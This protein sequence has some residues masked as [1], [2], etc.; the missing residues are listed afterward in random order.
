LDTET[1]IFV[2]AA[3]TTILVLATALCL[4][5]AAHMRNKTKDDSDQL[6]NNQEEE[7]Y[8]H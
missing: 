4:G 1:T 6:S 3:T 7:D 8:Q 5:I 2:A